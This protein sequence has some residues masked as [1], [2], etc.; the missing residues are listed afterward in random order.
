MSAKNRLIQTR[1]NMLKTQKSINMQK[2][3]TRNLEG[4]YRD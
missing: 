2:I 1:K 4:A 3:A